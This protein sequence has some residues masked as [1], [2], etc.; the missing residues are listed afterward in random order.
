MQYD[1]IVNSK[2]PYLQQLSLYKK[3]SVAIHLFRNVKLSQIM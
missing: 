2:R 3:M 1:T